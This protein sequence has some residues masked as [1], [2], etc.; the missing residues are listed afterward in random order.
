MPDRIAPPRPTP[1]QKPTMSP[2]EVRAVFGQNL[3]K[4]CD[5]G[6]PI[7]VLCQQIGINRTQFNRYLSGEAFPRPD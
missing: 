1:S 5:G 2:T 7:T 4:L 3:R 6:P